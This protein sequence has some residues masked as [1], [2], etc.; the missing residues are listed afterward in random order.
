MISE[1]EIDR[2]LGT[3][4][5]TLNKKEADASAKTAKNMQIQATINKKSRSFQSIGSKIFKKNDL[6]ASGDS[7]T[8]SQCKSSDLSE[9]SRLYLSTGHEFEIK[10]TDM[11]LKTNGVTPVSYIFQVNDMVSEINA[12]LEEQ[13]K[14]PDKKDTK[15]DNT[16]T[17]KDVLKKASGDIASL[18]MD[19]SSSVKLK[20]KIKTEQ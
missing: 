15:K 14:I 5:L 10:V 8:D 13:K 6:M 2:N 12:E 20:I 7:R 9:Q 4:A 16:K 1:W 19:Q 3:P 17:V 18:S 11:F